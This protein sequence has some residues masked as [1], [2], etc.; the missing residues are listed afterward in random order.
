MQL[1]RNIFVLLSQ[2]GIVSLR[3]LFDAETALGL[4]Y[5]RSQLLTQTSFSFR[6]VLKTKI[7]LA[8][9]NC[10]CILINVIRHDS[11]TVTV[12]D[13]TVFGHDRFLYSENSLNF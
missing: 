2:A 11:S 6:V 13:D 10:F 12:Q 1:V 5:N 8:N 3:V 7:A 4:R 9:A